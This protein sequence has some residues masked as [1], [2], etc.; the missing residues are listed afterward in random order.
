MQL[1]MNC[2]GKSRGILAI[3]DPE[4]EKNLKITFL[5]VQY[6]EQLVKIAMLRCTIFWSK[7]V[8]NKLK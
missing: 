5:T 8:Y 2:A 1:E 7:Y 4:F 3:A 6:N